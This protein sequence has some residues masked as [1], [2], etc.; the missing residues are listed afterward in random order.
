MNVKD[1]MTK[2]LSFASPNDTINQAADKMAKI[3]CGILPVKDDKN[4]CV[5]MITDRAIVLRILAKDEDPKKAT[6]K[7]AMTQS[8]YYCHEEDTIDEAGEMM[9]DHKVNRLLVKNKSDDIT[10]IITFGALLWKTKDAS[11][12]G[13]ML[14]SCCPCP[15]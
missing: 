15:T 1:I 7:D 5:G 4:D 10:G 11:K 6:V 12:V 9:R 13:S 2:E 14:A 8:V 3:N